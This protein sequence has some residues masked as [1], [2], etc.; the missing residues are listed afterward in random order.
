[1]G[2]NVVLRNSDWLSEGQNMFHTLGKDCLINGIL[3]Y[4]EILLPC[5]QC[6]LHHACMLAGSLSALLMGFNAS[7]CVQCL[8]INEF[9]LDSPCRLTAEKHRSQ[10]GTQFHTSSTIPPACFPLVPL[11]ST[12]QQGVL[13]ESPSFWKHQAPSHVKWY[14]SIG[15]GGRALNNSRNLSVVLDG[16]S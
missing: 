6:V 7:F 8:Q 16:H 2:A 9:S 11:S 10:L 5:P 4:N 12:K 3:F 15:T 1:M 14:Y 13:K